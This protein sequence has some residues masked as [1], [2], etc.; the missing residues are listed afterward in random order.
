[1][2]KKM[3]LQAALRDPGWFLWSV[4]HR[5][6]TL[7]SYWREGVAPPFV[8]SSRSSAAQRS[9]TQAFNADFAALVFGIFA[10]G[11]VAIPFSRL[12]LLTASAPLH[13]LLTFSVLHLEPRYVIPALGPLV[14]LGCYGASLLVAWLKQ[15]ARRYAPTPEPTGKSGSL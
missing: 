9:L 1:L 13:Y 3:W 10:C 2:L 11:I 4:W 8:A 6:G 15:V 5:C 7:L 14:F 12:G